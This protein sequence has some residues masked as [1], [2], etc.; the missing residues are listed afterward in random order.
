MVTSFNTAHVGQTY[1]WLKSTFNS[2]F[3][4]TF[5]M[6]VPT[7]FV[8]WPSKWPS[9]PHSSKLPIKQFGPECPSHPV[10]TPC[11]PFKYPYCTIFIN[12]LIIISIN[13][14]NRHSSLS[15]CHDMTHNLLLHHPAA[16]GD[17]EDREA[18]WCQPGMRELIGPHLF[19]QAL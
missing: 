12:L 19:W 10:P 5:W 13:L 1:Q 18:G 16:P 6:A 2:E 4:L 17:K 15:L 11:G 8:I 9:L 14:I 7:F 3:M